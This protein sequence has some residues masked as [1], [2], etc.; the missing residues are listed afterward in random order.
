MGGGEESL[1]NTRPQVDLDDGEFEECSG[2][3]AERAKARSRNIP[4]NHALF[5]NGDSHVLGDAEDL[6]VETPTAHSLAREKVMPNLSR[7]EFEAALGVGNSVNQE[8]SDK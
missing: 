7:E 5:A 8:E 3:R 6:H 4:P 1:I 2:R